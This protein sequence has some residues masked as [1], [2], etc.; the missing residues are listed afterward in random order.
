[1]KNKQIIFTNV[2]KAEL[3]EVAYPTI[4]ADIEHSWGRHGEKQTLEPFDR[5]KN[6]LVEFYKCVVGE[7]KNPYTFE[8]ELRMQM[9]VLKSCGFD[10][11]YKQKIEL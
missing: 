10:I 1:M 9:L 8:Y 4:G 3:S 11:D 6:M 5:Y 2:N 7:I